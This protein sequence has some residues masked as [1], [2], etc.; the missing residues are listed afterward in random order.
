[1]SDTYKFDLDEV[2]Q[3]NE[4]DFYKSIAL[5]NYIR[6]QTSSL[7]CITCD[8]TGSDIN[9]LSQHYLEGS[10]LQTIPPSDH[11]LWKDPQ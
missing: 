1:M 7:K 5:I 8:F 4:L 2:C 10:C 11:Q 3:K 6:L 9:Q